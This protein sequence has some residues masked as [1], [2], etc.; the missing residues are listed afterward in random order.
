MID[1]IDIFKS[2]FV[3]A[4]IDQYCEHQNHSYYPDKD[5][6][7]YILCDGEKEKQAVTKK[8]IETEK[9]KIKNLGFEELSFAYLLSSRQDSLHNYIEPNLRYD[10]WI[11]R[12]A[13]E[14][15]NYFETFKPITEGIIQ[16][17]NITELTVESLE[18]ES[19]FWSL[20]SEDLKPKV[21]DFLAIIA[22]ESEIILLVENT[23][24]DY[25]ETEYWDF[26]FDEF[27]KYSD[28]S[29][30]IEIL[31]TLS[32]LLVHLHRL[33]MFSEFIVQPQL[34]FQEAVKEINNAFFRLESFMNGNITEYKYFGFN[35][36]FTNLFNE[37]KKRDNFTYENSK[38]IGKYWEL[39]EQ[40]RVDY[41]QGDYENADFV[42]NEDNEREVEGFNNDCSEIMFLNQERIEEFHRFISFDV[43]REEE[44]KVSILD[45]LN[46]KELSNQQEPKRI[47]LRLA[48]IIT[49]QS[50][51]NIVEGIKIQYKNIQGK[52]LKI[53]LI[54]MQEMNILPKERIGK[55]FHTCCKSE[56]SWNIA[57]Y[58]AMNDYIFNK[59]T[60]GD[61]LSEMKSF[62]SK[63]INAK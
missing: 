26:D 8:Q 50:S 47:E 36:V 54:A 37:A 7:L 2:G 33:E 6:L 3:L 42:W 40:I 27:K 22:S 38:L 14:F 31:F 43:I 62:I 46:S 13:E 49:H 51:I 19:E 17:N 1:Q 60:D 41:D 44:R 57:S 9:E 39:T 29:K 61:E 20:Y 5:R 55:K 16:L 30:P 48:D 59:V 35:R 52:R 21:Q 4:F 24:E 45:I 56:F 11:N 28:V 53:L 34:S 12:F 25:N 23:I 10:F 18:N 15:E 32:E 58:T 63:I